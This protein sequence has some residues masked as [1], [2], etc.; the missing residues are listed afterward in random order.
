MAK[1][2]QKK[3]ETAEEIMGQ[4][5]SRR[6]VALALEVHHRTVLDWEK[7]GKEA[8]KN[9]LYKRFAE[10]IA[11]GEAH[12]ETILFERLNKAINEGIKTKK[13]KTITDS[14][15]NVTEQVT[16]NTTSAH[17]SPT[18]VR[19]ITWQLERKY[20]WDQHLKIEKERVL[21]SVIRVAEKSLSANQFDL[22]IEEIM[23][24]KLAEE[25]EIDFTFLQ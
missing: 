24:S 15:G 11:R 20:G 5:G 8:T 1:L 14:S 9:N 12:H 2:N 16:E 22:L 17:F 13:I 4:G 25:L 6:R 7:K 10:A 3:I 18:Q 21:N 19:A 23:Q